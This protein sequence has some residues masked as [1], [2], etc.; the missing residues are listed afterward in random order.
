MTNLAIQNATVEYNNY[1]DSVKRAFRIAY[2]AKCLHA[3]RHELFTMKH[4]EKEYH[5]TLY[6][7]DQA[8]NLTKDAAAIEASQ[9]ALP[10][11][12]WKG[13][14]LSLVLDMVAAMLAGGNA[15][16]QIPREPVRETGSSQIFLAIDP[17][18]VGYAEEMERIADGIIE[19]LHQAAPVDARKPVRY[20]GEETMR[21][22][23]EN[24]RLGVPVDPEIWQRISGA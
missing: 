11:G 18:S 9:R 7:F 3:Y 10:I 24:M 23:E 17:C 4:P 16:Y 2:T 13:S 21:V 14:G 6:Y 1:I 20:P 12:Y 15:T 5:Y 8:G 19:F 22:R